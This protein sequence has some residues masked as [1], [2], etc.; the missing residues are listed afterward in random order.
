MAKHHMVFADIPRWHGVVPSG[1]M[2]DFLGVKIRRKYGEKMP[3]VTF[4]P[5]KA[6]AHEPLLPP[7]DEE[8]FEWIDVIEAVKAA[9]NQFV[10]VELGAGYGRWLVRAVAALR[11]LNPMPYK[12]TAV[13][14][15]PTHFEWLKKHLRDNGIDPAEHQ[16]FKAAVNSTGERV[17]FYV[18]NPSGWYGQA[19][20]TG[21][22]G[23]LKQ[24][25]A[26][27]AS[28]VLRRRLSGKDEI[29]NIVW[30]KAVTLDQILTKHDRVD[31][32]DLDVQGAELDVLSAAI[33][34]LSRKVKRLHIGT[35]SAEIEEGL[36]KLFSSH[37]W[38]NVNDYRCQSLQQTPYGEIEFQD[39]VQTWVN[40]AL[41]PFACDTDALWCPH[42]CVDALLCPLSC[43]NIAS[44]QTRPLFS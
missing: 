39:G 17:R 23:T 19:I 30:V 25:V 1:Y 35:H 12:L 8:Y 37:G 2:V 41:L 7:F 29:V 33:E 27:W 6:M 10:M 20:A 14:P 9:K 24:R 32:I 34:P 22:T 4:G 44:P 11:R 16:L 43:T 42:Y 18:G 5:Q 26:A 15:E 3:G 21:S 31:L 13:E 38:D 40:P 28:T 36:R